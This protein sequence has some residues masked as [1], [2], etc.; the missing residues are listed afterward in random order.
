MAIISCRVKN[1]D[2]S[3][4]QLLNP[5]RQTIYFRDMRLPPGNPIIKND[6]MR[7]LSENLGQEMTCTAMS[8]KPAPHSDG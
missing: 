1:N 4:I 5:N 3:V 8:S 7:V 6:G 2:D